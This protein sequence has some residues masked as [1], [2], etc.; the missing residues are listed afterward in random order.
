MCVLHQIYLMS[1]GMIHPTSLVMVSSVSP[2]CIN[3]LICFLEIKVFVF[4]IFIQ[5]I[6]MQSCGVILLKIYIMNKQEFFVSS[7]ELRTLCYAIRFV[8]NC[9]YRSHSCLQKSC[10]LFQVLG[11]AIN[12][13]A[14]KHKERP[15]RLIDMLTSIH[16][17]VHE[18]WSRS[19]IQ[20][21]YKVLFFLCISLM[22]P[23]WTWN[24]YVH[25]T[26]PYQLY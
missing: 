11:A 15:D 26:Y 24:L 17:F 3:L 21:I 23:L 10:C 8:D 22:F 19:L 20:I 18:P 7:S 13:Y 1:P 6:F 5:G 16:R 9:E 14:N 4:S 12:V 2:W 25:V